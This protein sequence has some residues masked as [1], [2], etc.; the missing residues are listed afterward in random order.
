MPPENKD[1]KDKENND[2]PNNAASQAEANLSETDLIQ[3]RLQ[4]FK[5]LQD[6]GITIYPNRFK[7][8]HS[9]RQVLDLFKEGETPSQTVTIAGRVMSKRPMGK[10]GFCNLHD[11]TG[12]IQIYSNNTLLNEQDHFVFSHLDIGDI[13]GISGETFVTKTGEPSI[14]AGKF[15]I[16]SKNLFPLPAAKEKDG[17]RFD[18]FSDVEQRYRRRY[19]DLIVN[20]EV[21][22]TFTLRSQIINHIRQFLSTKGF[23]EVET[24]MMHSIASGAAARPFETHH[25]TLDMDLFLRIA[26]ELHLKRLIAGGFEKVFELNRNFRNEGIS[27]K[28]NPEFTMMEIYEAY[29]DYEDMMDL[30][31]SLITGVANTV[32]GTEEIKYGEKTISLKKPWPRK[33]YLEAI[34]EKTGLD[35]MAC[36]ATENFTFSEAEKMAQSIGVSTKN[37]HTAWEVVDAVFSEKVE[38]SLIQPVFIT[39]FPKAMSPL[40]KSKPNEPLL[41]ERFEPYINGW[42]IGNAFTE[43]ND[44][45]DQKERFEQQVKMKQ[46]GQSEVIEMD[47]D[48]IDALKVGMPPTGGLGIGID[49]LIMLMTNSPSIKDVIFFPLL[50]T[51]PKDQ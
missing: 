18:A 33:P 24:P 30:A 32:L 39:D 34:K 14:R 44:P 7:R 22:K 46:E 36:L 43:L 35:F 40:A 48:F 27:I 17:V 5:S 41:V 16:L 51:T 1:N 31:E 49:R 15:N 11:L 3:Q 12:N 28:H 2:N 13:V 38:G 26:P 21:R 50:K 10:A 4:K 37:L 25:N 6:Q 8:D 42:E 45:F 23:L 19:L 29:A 9:I 47:E 20:P